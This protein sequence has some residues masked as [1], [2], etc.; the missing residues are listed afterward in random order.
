[1]PGVGGPHIQRQ[2]DGASA[3]RL[4]VDRPGGFHRLRLLRHGDREDAIAE[5]RLDLVAVRTLRHAEGTLEGAV[6]PLG[7]IVPLALLFLLFL[8]LTLDCQHVVRELEFNI[9]VGQTRQFGGDEIVFVTFDDFHSGRRA[10]DPRRLERGKRA[11]EAPQPAVEFLEQAIY[12]TAKTFKRTPRFYC[13]RARLLLRGDGRLCF[14]I[15]HAVFP[16][17]AEDWIGALPPSA[18]DN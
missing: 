4:D 14:N 2:W 15:S 17:H 7:E 6:S 3:A 11:R 5:F 8:L 13:G 16:P 18:S 12:F 9:L 10:A 1:G